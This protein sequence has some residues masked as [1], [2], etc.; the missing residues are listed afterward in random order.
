[1]G[2]GQVLRIDHIAGWGGGREDEPVKVAEKEANKLG[3]P[4]TCSVIKARRDR[5]QNVQ[6]PLQKRKTKVIK[7][8]KTTQQRIK[9]STGPLLSLGSC[10]P[11]SP[12][13]TL[14]RLAPKPRSS[15]IPE[16]APCQAGGDL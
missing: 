9:S 7:D 15:G 4:D 16:V 13:R 11:K 10:V 8:F 2:E 1:M 3:K 14:R 6:G 5:L 12:A